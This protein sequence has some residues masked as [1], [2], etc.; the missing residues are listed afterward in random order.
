MLKGILDYT[1]DKV[2]SC[3]FNGDTHS[4]TFNAAGGIDL[5][6]NFVKLISCYGNKHGYSLQVVGLI[7]CICL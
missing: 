7:A 5:N 2:L 6:D 4:F 1:G 3:D